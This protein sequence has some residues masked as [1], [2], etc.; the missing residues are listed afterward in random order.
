MA[1]MTWSTDKPTTAGWYWYQPPGRRARIVEVA[2]EERHVLYIVHTGMRLKDLPP[3]EI[4]WAGPIQEP[5]MTQTKWE[6]LP[7]KQQ[8]RAPNDSQSVS[9]D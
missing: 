2:M 3:D 6:V 9:H 4:E 5:P 7:A 1:L 8:Q